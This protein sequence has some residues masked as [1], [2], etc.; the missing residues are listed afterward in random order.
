MKKKKWIMLLAVICFAIVL[1]PIPRR[2]R[3][4]GSVE[5][6]AI[7][8]RITKV[9]QFYENNSQNLYRDGIK[10]EILGKEIYSSVSKEPTSIPEEKI[11]WDAITENGV[12]EELLWSQ[13]NQADLATIAQILQDTIEE[14]IQEERENPELVVQE[15]WVRIF[16][17]EGYRQ[18]VEMGEKAAKPL[19]WILY[20][21]KNAGLYEYLCSHALYEIMELNMQQANG[22]FTWSN[23]KE[24]LEQF[25]QEMRSR[26]PKDFTLID[27][28]RKEVSLS[29]FYGKPMVL[30][31][32]ASWCSPC[33]E[34][35]PSIEAAYQKYQEKVHFLAINMTSWGEETIENA[36]HLI[37]EKNYHFPV[38]FDLNAS[39]EKAYQIN[40]IPQIRFLNKDGSVYQS[41][42]K[43]ASEQE[44]I[45][46]IE[47][48]LQK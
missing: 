3:D 48:M 45:E 2:L 14:E 5:Y 25:N 24:F 20:K 38:Y 17:K 39:V 18:V 28:E 31:F 42:Q 1:V 12:N 43:V 16:E 15:G 46:V 8:Y 21:S 6:M 23:A 40:Y 22:E 34:E 13:V 47:I 32:W 30:V 9:H 36:N 19:Y 41:S 26:K 37:N 7:L 10:I 35:L 11:S 4:G 33:K 27:Q 29:E 44:I